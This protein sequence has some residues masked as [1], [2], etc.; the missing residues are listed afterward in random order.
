MFLEVTLSLI[1]GYTLWCL[2][3]REVNFRRASSMGIPLVRLFVDPKNIPWLV[4]EPFVWRI[5]D[6]IPLNYG[7]LRYSR[8][9][10]HFHDKAKSHIQY[11]PVW[12]LVTPGDVYIYIADPDAVH[13]IFHRRGEFLRPSEMYSEYSPEIHIILIS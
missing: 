4:I 7:T 10:W 12:A 8:R 5:L 6:C 9:G 11:G 2:A 3:A 1:L 13:D